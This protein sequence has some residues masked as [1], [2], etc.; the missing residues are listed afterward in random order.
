MKVRETVPVTVAE[1]HW[2]GTNTMRESEI[3]YRL[4]ATKCPLLELP[5]GGLYGK[6]IPRVSG[7]K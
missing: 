3:V 1:K 4:L 2:N 7:H 6:Y 5:V